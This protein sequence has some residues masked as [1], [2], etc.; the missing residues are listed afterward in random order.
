[1]RYLFFVPFVLLLTGC[2]SFKPQEPKISS[3]K[4]EVEVN[5]STIRENVPLSRTASPDTYRD[6]VKL[7]SAYWEAVGNHNKESLLPLITSKWEKRLFGQLNTETK[8]EVGYGI[9]KL[10]VKEVIP[11]CQV[12][13]KTNSRWYQVVT[14]I[15]PKKGE[16]AWKEGENV[17]YINT[18]LE[19]GRWLVSEANMLPRCQ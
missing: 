15:T 7:A 17:S 3:D 4:S 1:M 2:L 14:N 6:P 13:W 16:I 18:V 19:E 5:P 9:E 11:H 10:S 8:Y 12:L